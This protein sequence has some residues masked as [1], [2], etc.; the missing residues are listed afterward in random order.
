MNRL[1]AQGLAVMAACFTTSAALIWAGRR[2]S[3][4]HR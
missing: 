3:G 2:L 4:G 1:A